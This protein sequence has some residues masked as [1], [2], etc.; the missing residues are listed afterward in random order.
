M[1]EPTLIDVV[2][3]LQKRGRHVEARRILYATV[4]ALYSRGVSAIEALAMEWTR[5]EEILMEPL[6]LA[7]WD[8]TCWGT[9]FEHKG[10]DSGK[11]P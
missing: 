3:A 6:E 7:G 11:Q 5:I 8:E 10:H 2:E 4:G 9:G 1:T